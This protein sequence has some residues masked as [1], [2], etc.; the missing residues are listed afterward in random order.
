MGK[1]TAIDTCG[2]V[3]NRL[4]YNYQEAQ[5]LPRG[6]LGMGEASLLTQIEGVMHT[7]RDL[8]V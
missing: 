6:S 5:K 1:L 8:W 2:V 3:E 7:I 4:E